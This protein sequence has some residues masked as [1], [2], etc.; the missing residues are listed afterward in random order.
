MTVINKLA[1]SLNRRDE[2]PNVDLA[3][4]IV[5]TTDINAIQEL[6]QNLNHK[7]KGIRQDCIKVLYEVGERNPALIARYANEFGTL[8]ES[9][10]NRLQW[11][12][13]TALDT[14]A[15]EEPAKIYEMLS[16][17]LDVADKGSVISRDRAVGILIKL[18]SLKPH[19]KACSLLL[20][21]QLAKCPNNQ[22]PMYIENSIGIIND[23]NRAQF[24]DVVTT[25]IDRLD[26]ES[27]EK[28]LRK[29]LKKIG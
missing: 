3:A 5:Q 18:A 7:S 26:K 1:A 8:L 17:I 9:K 21:E 11:G 4:T 16:K 20:L 6:V 19:H 22:F 12:A 27:E 25:R 2:G 23:E 24:R 28:R 15:L 14:I 29:A 10:D 13:M